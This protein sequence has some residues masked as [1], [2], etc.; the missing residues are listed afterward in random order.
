MSNIPDNLKYTQSHEWVRMEEDGTITV[1]ITE[2]AQEQLGDL[3]FVELPAD[4]ESVNAEDACGVVESVK[5][6][7]DI[8]SPI[9]GEI[10]EANASLTD[11]PELVNQS[12][13]ETG[14]LFRMKPTSENGLENLLTAQQYTESIADSE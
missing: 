10:I 3:V 9:A 1:G 11:E 2:H 8:F 12:P 4:G 13:Y 6:A 14:W 7:S 5:A